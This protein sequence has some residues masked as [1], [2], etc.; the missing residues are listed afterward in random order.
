MTVQYV[1]ARHLVP[2]ELSKICAAVCATGVNVPVGL[3][4]LLPRD[5]HQYDC[6]QI[7]K[8]GLSSPVVLATYF[9]EVTLAA[10]IGFG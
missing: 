2:S 1:S 3:D 7:L 4:R 6:V 9:L 5:R 10:I 8:C